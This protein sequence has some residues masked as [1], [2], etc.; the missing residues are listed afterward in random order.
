MAHGI[1][2]YDK[3]Y[4]H[5]TTWHN[6][7]QFVQ[8]DRPVTFEEALEVMD[9]PLEKI[10]LFYRHESEVDGE[11]EVD[12]IKVDQWA[13]R[14][15][16]NGQVLVPG[17]GKRFDVLNNRVLLDFVKRE[18]LDIYPE[19][20]I[21]SVGT[22]FGG[23]TSFLNLKIDEYHIKGDES[24]TLSRLMYANPLGNGR[25]RACAHNVRVVCNNTLR[26]AEAQGAA[27]QTLATISHTVSA[28]RRIVEHLSNLAEISLGLQA[29]RH[30]LDWLAT[31][32]VDSH[33]VQKFLEQFYF[34]DDTLAPA[35]DRIKSNA[36]KK[37]GDI[38]KIFES[39]EH[40]NGIARTRYALLQ[41]TTRHLGTYSHGAKSDA[42]AIE[43]DALD[44]Q[45]AVKKDRAL[46]L[47]LV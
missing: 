20:E 15:P 47:L 1:T 23:A 32:E 8:L 7:D 39:Q 27:N 33:Y 26:A 25:Y 36:Q 14:R 31:Q 18:F 35:S 6:M 17:V 12:F 13:I 10:Q 24:P 22:L 38:L 37:R 41:A 4:V 2:F 3:G 9:Y 16:D 19:L 45:R 28:E 42:S 40:L 44:G 11:R 21:E 46:E 29:H 5:G 43:W 34:V 30:K